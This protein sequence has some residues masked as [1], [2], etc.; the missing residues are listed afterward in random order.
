[1]IFGKPD[2]NRG[3][4]HIDYRRYLYVKEVQ[5]PGLHLR[6]QG[7]WY[8]IRQYTNTWTWCYEMSSSNKAMKKVKKLAIILETHN[9]FR[10]GITNVVRIV[11]P[12]RSICSF[13]MT[14]MSQSTASNMVISKLSFST[15]CLFKLKVTRLERMSFNSIV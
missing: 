13:L 4:E 10:I 8:Q 14:M 5:G 11:R 9:H 6:Y 3:L 12:V 2:Q 1:M 7:D 15:R